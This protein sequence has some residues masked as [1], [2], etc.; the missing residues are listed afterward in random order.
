MLRMTVLILGVCLA[1]G[2]SQAQTG[3]L[4]GRQIMLLNEGSRRAKKSESGRVLLLM[5]DKEGRQR[6]LSLRAIIDDTDQRL[7]KMFVEFVAPED[8]RGVRTLSI[9]RADLEDERWIYLP[10]IS[11]KRRITGGSQTASFMG[12]DFTFEDFSLMDGEVAGASRSY[13]I[14]GEQV[15][16]G[17]KCWVIESFP[18]TEKLKRESAHNRR[19]IWVEQ[20]HYIAVREEFYDKSGEL[21]K[22]MTREDIRMTEGGPTQSLRPHKVVMTS[23]KTG[24]VSELIFQELVLDRDFDPQMLTPSFLEAGTWK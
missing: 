17:R 2:V 18:V 20:E 8:I 6:S 16:Q 4:T 1:A 14:Q 15:M 22:V 23:T 12:S 13:T 19:L 11:T 9:A 24:H 21:A 7:R 3:T 10:A 5:R